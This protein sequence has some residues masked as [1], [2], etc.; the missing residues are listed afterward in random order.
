M[1]DNDTDTSDNDEE[2]PD[3]KTKPYSELNPDELEK[4]RA[5]RKKEKE[6]ERQ[7]YLDSRPDNPYENSPAEK[8]D[9]VP[10][11]DGKQPETVDWI[12]E[13]RDDDSDTDSGDE[14]DTSR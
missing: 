8:S 13:S 11:I 12:A 3:W 5:F 4:A 14:N 1:T 6:N 9:V 2:K 10:P 7:R